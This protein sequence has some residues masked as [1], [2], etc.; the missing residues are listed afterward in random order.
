MNLFQVSDYYINHLVNEKEGKSKKDRI[1]S[2]N[3]APSSVV[4]GSRIKVLLLDEGTTS[5]ISLNS[6]QSELLEHDIYLITRID[7][8]N[9][10]KMRH[11]TA[12][13]YLNATEDSINYLLDE[14]RNPKY[15]TYEIYFN[16][17]VSKVQ[18]ERLAESDDMEVVT[19]VQEIFQDY[20]TINKELFSFNLKAP[21]HR[22][23]GDHLNSWTGH[24]LNRVTQGLTSLLLSLKVKPIIR[25]EANSRM[26]AKLSQDLVHNIEKTNS[27]LFD[28]KTQD[29]P[30]LLLILD[31]KN[32]PITPLLIPWTFQS[33][34]HEL[35]GIE[36]NTVDL[37]NTPSISKEL[38][39]IVLSS[40]QDK[41]Y[42]ES[43]YLNFGD[44]SDKIKDYV[45]QYK[46]K[47]NS[48]KKIESIED[49]KQFIEEFPEFKKLSGNVSKHM[50]LASELNRQIDLLRLWEVSEVEQNLSSHDQHNLDLQEIEKLL[51]D[52]NEDPSKPKTPVANDLKLKLVILYALR[53]EKNPN[54][55]IPRLKS[56]LQ[57]QGISLQGIAMVDYFLQ[58]SGINQRLD[59]EESIFDK[60]TSNLM[61]GLKTNH[62]TDN[63]FMQH[64][65]RLE[66]IISKAVRGKLSE[67]DYPILSP[68]ANNEYYNVNLFTEK[69]QD[70]IVFFVGG[71]TYEEARIIENL[72]KANSHVRIILGGTAIHNTKSFLTEI[73]DAGSR[74]PKSTATGRLHARVQ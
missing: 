24:S 17:I 57:N 18:L 34:V 36:N 37:S 15:A 60:A 38:E 4:P 29:T 9:R 19:K 69:A 14:L 41:F 35:L 16:N 42:E 10:D 44:L 1:G 22:I 21:R 20:L 8:P 23:Y 71:T 46:S 53:Y 73:E 74:W 59:E 54:N 30:P 52:Q 47:T 55:Q 28:F 50:T 61:S 32:D 58:W 13:C 33:M 66:G 70:I 72:N 64:V 26:A 65:P 49:M 48:K 25:H 7:N 45:F 40:K 51:L 31:R 43:M 2:Y 6:T 39:K 67:R 62:N 11:L 5:I 12:I 27:S 3:I 63:I 56:I 68:Y